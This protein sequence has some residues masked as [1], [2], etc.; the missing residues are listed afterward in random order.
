MGAML[1][2]ARKLYVIEAG[3]RNAREQQINM[4]LRNEPQRLVAILGREDNPF[5]GADTNN[6][7]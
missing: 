1:G 3:H 2:Y 4:P 7:A 6:W 5:W